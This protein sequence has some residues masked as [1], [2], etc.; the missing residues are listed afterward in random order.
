MKMTMRFLSF[1]WMGLLLSSLTNA[2]EWKQLDSMRIAIQELNY[3]GEFLHRRGDDTSVYSIVHRF[4]YQQSTELLRQLDGDM[5]EVLRQGDKMVCYYP[6]GSEEA[7]NH[8]VP[9]APFSQVGALEL[10]RISKN[11]KAMKIG[12]AR[13]AGY[14]T[15]I[16]E[17]TG[18]EWRFRQR[19]WLEQ[20]TNVL[21][22]SELMSLEGEVLEQ[23]RFTRIE[24]GVA[25][26]DVELVPA[27]EGNV[28]ARQQSAF[29][30][31]AANL[32]DSSFVSQADWLPKGYVLTHTSKKS[33]EKGWLEQRTY[34]DGLTSFSIF[35]ESGK[36][37]GRQ[38]SALAKMGAT[39]ALMT[40]KDDLA[41][42]IIGEIPSNTAKQIA[43]ML[44]QK[45]S[46]L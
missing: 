28:N 3:R 46:S 11:Y 5:V 17:L 7:L 19:F 35:V 22:Q 29:K 26:D 44:S 12:Q 27:L 16:I 39:T 18:D 32:D 15:N 40:S 4:E 45:S 43:Q 9:A 10:D 14:Q 33:D 25:I 21:L 20:E 42:T 6:E 37:Q 31:L 24:L 36:P 13:V 8:A 38:S 23:F 30:T 34:S 41:V 1:V 2:M